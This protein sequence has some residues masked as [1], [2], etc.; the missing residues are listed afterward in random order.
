MNIFAI[1]SYVTSKR[2]MK[3]VTVH[4]SAVLS[5]TKERATALHTTQYCIQPRA[6]TIKE[7]IGTRI[8]LV[9]RDLK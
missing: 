6:K 4:Q 9:S 3:R 7:S 1:N 2:E 5:L 8:L